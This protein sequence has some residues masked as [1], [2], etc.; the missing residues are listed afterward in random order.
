MSMTDNYRRLHAGIEDAAEKAKVALIVAAERAMRNHLEGPNKGDH[1]WLVA[2]VKLSTIDGDTGLAVS[3]HG[4]LSERR[5]W[6]LARR[7]EGRTWALGPF[8]TEQDVPDEGEG[9]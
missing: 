9:G 1:G 8:S 2:R 3:I 7:L 6:Q 4:P 5:A